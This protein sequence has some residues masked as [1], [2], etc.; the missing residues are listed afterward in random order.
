[1]GEHEERPMSIEE[2]TETIRRVARDYEATL[3]EE[4]RE[5]VW[6]RVVKKNNLDPGTP[7][8]GTEKRGED[9]DAP[10]ASQDR[11]RE[12]GGSDPR[13]RPGFRRPDAQ[14]GRKPL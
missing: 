8:P 3:T 14:R 7:R 9:G 2:A 1:M 13:H 12:P 11:R 5:E 4:Q 6:Q 10:E